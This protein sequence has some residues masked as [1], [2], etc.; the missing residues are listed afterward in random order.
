MIYLNRIR[1]DFPWTRTFLSANTQRTIGWPRASLEADDSLETRTD[2][3]PAEKRA[4]LVELTTQGEVLVEVPMRRPDGR[5]LLGPAAAPASPAR[6]ADG[7]VYV[8]GYLVDITGEQNLTAQMQASAK[9]ATLGEMAT[10]LAHE[11]GQP[12][13]TMCLAARNAARALR[14]PR[15]GGRSPTRSEA[16]RP[17]HR[18]GRADGGA[19]AASEGLRPGRARSCSARSAWGGRCRA[20]WC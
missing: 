3:T 8:V 16:A 20:R 18:P 6:Y 4:A 13:A 19:D 1:P 9:L 7:S 14:K 10:G 17:H 5:L 11:L 2:W 15:R 12:A